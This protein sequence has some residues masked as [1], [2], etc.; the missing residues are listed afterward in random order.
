MRRRGPRAAQPAPPGALAFGEDDEPL[1]QAVVA[2]AGGEVVRGIG[3]LED[4]DL[5]SDERVGG[6]RGAQEVG[7]E[8]RTAAAGHGRNSREKS[9]ARAEWVSAPTL[10]HCT[11]VS[12]MA[13]TVSRW[14]PPLASNWTG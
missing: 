1:G 13:R 3:F 5:A 8:T 12:A 9:M 4:E 6:Q 10:I 11:P 14:T 2:G 7:I